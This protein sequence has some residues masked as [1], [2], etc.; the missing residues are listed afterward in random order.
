[1]S[2]LLKQSTARDIVVLMI[3]STDH[4]TG[5]TGLTLTISLSKNAAAFASITPTVTELVSGFY[6]LALTSTHT[7][8][9][10]DFALHITSTG[11]DPTDLLRQVVARLPGE[12]VD[13]GLINGTTVNGDG[14]SG[15]PW[16]P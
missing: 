11:A 14:S 9:L 16:G 13:V 6:K 2:T 12:K 8:T 1:M 7:D 5:K 4:V 3:D 10:G 15:N